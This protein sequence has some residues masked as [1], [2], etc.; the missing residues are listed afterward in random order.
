MT[1]RTADTASR[2]MSRV[3]TLVDVRHHAIMTSCI[4]AVTGTVLLV[5]AWM[6][7]GPMIE[8]WTGIACMAITVVAGLIGATAAR[9]LEAMLKDRPSLA[10]V[11]AAAEEGLA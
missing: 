8:R 9:R 3:L 4:A 11:A 5:H 7:A 1:S 10:P 6:S 2:D